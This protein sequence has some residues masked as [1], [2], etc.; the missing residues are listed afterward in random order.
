MPTPKTQ[1]TT[2]EPKP[3]DKWGPAKVLGQGELPPVGPNVAI[4]LEFKA[5]ET[6]NNP[7][8]PYF[9]GNLKGGTRYDGF[10]DNE[11]Q[12]TLFDLGTK[13][14]FYIFRLYDNGVYT[15]YSRDM[16]VA[17][18]AWEEDAVR[19]QTLE[20]IKTFDQIVHNPDFTGNIYNQLVLLC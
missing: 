2:P 6:S 1:D 19:L 11:S 4:P 17:P 7:K 16:Y 9:Y 12:G 3:S 13:Q 14:S 10:L 20:A 15:W 18:P 5:S 8:V